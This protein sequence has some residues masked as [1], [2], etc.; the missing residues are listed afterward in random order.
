MQDAAK[1]N[2]TVPI[3]F[4]RAQVLSPAK[5]PLSKHCKFCDKWEKKKVILKNVCGQK[6]DCKK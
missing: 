5:H 1:C 3:I 2:V 4:H 6:S